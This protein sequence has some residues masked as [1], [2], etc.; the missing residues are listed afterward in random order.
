MFWVAFAGAPALTACSLLLGEGF[1]D[2]NAQPSNE[3][4][5]G[6]DTSS[7]GGGATLPSEGGPDADASN[8]RPD[9]GDGGTGGCP[10]GLVSFC[11]DFERGDASDVQG[12][13]EIVTLNATGALGLQTA[14]SGNHLL[15]ASVSAKGDDAYLSKVFTK[16]P[17]KFH[18]ELSLQV[19]SLASTGGVY[20]TGIGMTNG[21]GSPS[22][23]YLYLD[24]TNLLLVQQVA[25]GVNYFSQAIPI[26]LKT[27]HRISVD[28]TFNGRVVVKVDGNT[29]L[30]QNAQT[31]LVPKPPTVILGASSIDDQGDDGAFVADDFVFTLD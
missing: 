15:A 7:D 19:D 17:S 12:T 27:M 13:W 5:T 10:S 20:V 23:V 16:Q 28:L 1:T 25:D 11:D 24:T 9:G 14:S 3:A 21:G 29:K 31:F 8:V 18:L 4:G 2:P 26:T 6:G 22:L 30:D